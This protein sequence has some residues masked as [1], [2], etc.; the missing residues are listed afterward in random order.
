MSIPISTISRSDQPQIRVDNSDDI[1][2][3]RTD[4]RQ[5]GMEY[6][7]Y[8]TEMVRSNGAPRLT[9]TNSID[10]IKILYIEGRVDGLRTASKK[11]Q[12]TDTPHMFDLEAF[13]MGRKLTEITGNRD[14]KELFEEI[15]KR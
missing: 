9:D 13:D 11:M 1:N 8:F 3:L 7:K 10:I 14:P 6:T 2:S 12:N 5:L 4:K 15:L